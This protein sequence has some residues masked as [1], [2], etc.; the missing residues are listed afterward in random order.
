MSDAR[1]VTR[2]NSAGARPGRRPSQV[3]QG[4]LLIISCIQMSEAV[5]INIRRWEKYLQ[6]PFKLPP[7]F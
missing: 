7:P 4:L 2:G 6:C 1:L 5:E 3:H